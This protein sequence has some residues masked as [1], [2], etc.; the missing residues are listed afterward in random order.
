MCR[1]LWLQFEASLQKELSAAAEEKDAII[2]D[3]SEMDYNE[4][5]SGWATKLQRVADG[6]QKWGMFR[7]RKPACHN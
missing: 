2:A 3:F 4:V 7:A 5:S 6:E 1:L